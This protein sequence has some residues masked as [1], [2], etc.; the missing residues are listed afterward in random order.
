MTERPKTKPVE[1]VDAKAQRLADATESL[2]PSAGFDDWIMS[3]IDAEPEASLL[4]R[5]WSPGKRMLAIGAF[6][7]AASVM[8]AVQT[9]DQVDNDVMMAFDLVEL[10]E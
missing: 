7:A 10:E 4:D 2:A 9:Q 6:A 5:V 3:A 8:F 1:T